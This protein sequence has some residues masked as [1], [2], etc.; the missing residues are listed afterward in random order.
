MNPTYTFKPS[1]LEKFP[2]TSKKLP[3]GSNLRFRLLIDVSESEIAYNLESDT[4][5][6]KIEA[7]KTFYRG[8]RMILLRFKRIFFFE[9]KRC[10]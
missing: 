7:F 6:I 10:F 5:L 4:E 9:N 8:S 3:Y 2:H 1:I